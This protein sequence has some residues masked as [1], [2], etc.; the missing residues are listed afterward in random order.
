MAKIL[1]LSLLFGLLSAHL[2]CQ[3][4][5]EFIRRGKHFFNNHEYE[6]ALVE[7]T[8]AKSYCEIQ[9][10]QKVDIEYADA[11]GWL[12]KSMYYCNIDKRETFEP[13]L[14]LGIFYHSI[15]AIDFY[16]M[17]YPLTIKSINDIIE[18]NKY[19]KKELGKIYYYKA[20]IYAKGNS[21]DSY[22]LAFNNLHKASQKNYPSKQELINN[23]WIA[24]CDPEKYYQLL[25]DAGIIEN[26]YSYAIKRY[27]ENKIN[28]WQKKDKF[29]K[30]EEYQNRVSEQQR[31]TQ[32]G[33]FTQYYIDSLGLSKTNMHKA[34]NEYDADNE[35]F[36]LSF[37][38]SETIFIPVPINEAPLFD[39]NF[40]IL[41]FQNAT[42]TLYKDRFELV[43]LDIYNPK[44][45]KTYG[46]NSQSVSTF[47]PNLLTYT[48][49]EIELPSNFNTANNNNFDKSNPIK[50][51]DVDLNIPENGVVNQNKYALIIGNEDYQSYQT[52]L[53]V[54]QN[55]EFAIKDASI[56]KQYCIKTLGV[57]S[58]N[59]IFSTNAGAVKMR[60]QINQLKS[61][62]TALEGEA[63]IIVYYAGHGFPD[64]TTKEP[65]LIPVDVPGNSLELALNLKNIV[66]NLTEK[67]SK[68]IVF[69]I[70][71]CFSG[72][73]RENGLLVSRGVKIIPKETTAKGNL[74]LFSASSA[75]Q[76]ALPYTEKNHGLFTYYLLKK[77]QET[78]GEVKLGELD[79][80]LS[81]EVSIKSTMILSREQNPKTQY[82]SSIRNEWETW[83]LK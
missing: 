1:F 30:T 64:E 35:V 42:F 43:H 73:G 60:Q 78:Q 15:D 82:S 2:Y 21:P 54:E 48:F 23:K 34:K 13:T 31:L 63:E 51:V 26:V 12:A 8:K 9:Q 58:E 52:G 70:D 61:I 36:K 18:K 62:I 49:D 47:N 3:N 28:N 11:C 57:P 59:I 83:K 76:S 32:I 46:Y 24:D 71:A 6:K 37:A 45:D 65:Y 74:V 68:Q 72:G 40:S 69:F 33:I 29:E 25:Y 81:K 77:L 55:V 10:P 16:A 80:Y 66:D 75:E 50:L 5:T 41:D 79:Q 4:Q 56:F 20:N 44:I 17:E 22:N 38:N 19:A 39:R 7:F 14:A 67:P 27:V 53:S